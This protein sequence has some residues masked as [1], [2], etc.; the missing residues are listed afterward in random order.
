MFYAASISSPDGGR[1]LF[2][3]AGKYNENNGFAKAPRVRI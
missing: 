3:N 2:A 1:N